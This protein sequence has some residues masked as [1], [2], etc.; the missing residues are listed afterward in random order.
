MT[1]EDEHQL[2]E[3]R[4]KEAEDAVALGRVHVANQV[5]V[6]EELRRDGHDTSAAEEL[7]ETLLRSQELHEERRDRLRQELGLE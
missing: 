7:L 4:L 1:A 3:Q 5:R 2:A 6:L